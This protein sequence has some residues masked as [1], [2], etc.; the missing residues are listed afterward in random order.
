MQC[1]ICADTGLVI[2]RPHRLLGATY[3]PED[4]WKGDEHFSPCP[5]CSKESSNDKARCLHEHLE[6]TGCPFKY[7][8]QSCQHWI[9]FSFGLD[10]CKEKLC[11]NDQCHNYGEKM[12]TTARTLVQVFTQFHNASVAEAI[13]LGQRLSEERR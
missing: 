12:N 11:K 9:T 3:P 13:E 5:L 10:P 2:N 6:T 1:A 4:R 7:Y 8:C